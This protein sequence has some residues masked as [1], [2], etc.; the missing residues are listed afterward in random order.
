MASMLAAAA[1]LS[2]LAVASAP[3]DEQ[4]WSFSRESLN[5][6]QFLE[7]GK[8]RPAQFPG[9]PKLLDGGRGVVLDG[10][11]FLTVAPALPSTELPEE[12]LTVEAWVLLDDIGRWGG[13]VSAVE[14]NPGE[15]KGFVLGFRDSRFCFAIATEEHPTLEYVKA[16]GAP[17]LGRWYHVAGTYDGDAAKLYVDGME[18]AR[19]EKPGGR[20]VYADQHQFV[21]GCLKD[22]D[23][24]HPMKGVLLEASL[25]SDSLSS[26]KVSQRFGEGSRDLPQ[27]PAPEDRGVNVATVADIQEKINQAIDKGANWIM[28]RQ[29]RD[30]SWEQAQPGYRNGMTALA[31]YAALKSGVSAEDPGIARALAFLAAE[32]PSK[33]YSAGI[34]MMLIKHLGDRGDRKQAGRI[35]DD[36]LEWERRDFGGGYGYPTGHVDLSCT[37]YGALGL[38]AAHDMGFEAPR[39]VWQRMLE[40]TTT[41][42]MGPVNE[43]RPLV[44]PSGYKGEAA[45]F[46]YR[47][48]STDTGG[49]TTAGLT[50][51]CLAELCAGRKLGSKNLRLVESSK[52]LGAEWL[53]HNWSVSNNPGGG[54][55][56]YYLYGL[57]RVAALL[58]ADVIAGHDW[59]REG[60][61]HLISKQRG[62]G[63]W[64]DGESDTAF[65]LLFLVKA[66]A[67]NTGRSAA[68]ASRAFVR[69]RGPLQFRSTGY[70]RLATWFDRFDEKVL[71]RF[72]PEPGPRVVSMEWLVDGK[73]VTKLPGDPSRPWS[74]ERFAT[75]IELQ[76]PGEAKVRCV[77]TVLSPGE[78]P[79]GKTETL[80]S[81]EL[82]VNAVRDPKEF[83]QAT[84]AFQ[85][86]SLLQEAQYQVLQSSIYAD[87]G[88]YTG[89]M[90]FDNS[91]A[92]R[93]F[94]KVEDK[95][96]WVR[97]ELEKPL[98]AKRIV[99]HPVASSLRME[100]QW[101][102][103]ASATILVN[104]DYEFEV[105]FPAN[106]LMPVRAEIPTKKPI[107]SLE[108]RLGPSQR[109]GRQPGV[110]GLAEITLEK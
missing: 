86:D 30:G 20:I 66:T 4:R 9:T 106:E 74:G 49:M 79:G 38:W 26:R 39:E 6:E 89:A 110:R 53:A 40:V 19:S 32:D 1:L 47:P 101:D 50:V 41:Q 3:Q 103:L 54:H 99:L 109:Q 100:G 52:L 90:A 82:T 57:E 23:A 12:E 44:N 11:Q 35:F 73:Q 76:D 94:A 95:T 108:V 7:A 48:E 10:Q 55:P 93:W 83:L 68:A 15:L 27:P 22:K 75:R 58:E 17:I 80:E 16:P 34:Q 71:E 43:V 25:E 69:D 14:H 36:L 18:V 81:D 24:T 98:R 59:Y 63:S 77:F 72:A 96:P 91:Q 78:E 67:S 13:L 65:A 97:I 51:A 62:N 5:G 85:R 28:S 33:T 31:T 104:G 87:D 60:A 70:M 2:A 56:Y 105:E 21:L 45:G 37:Q 107:R 102:T 8:G 88:R 46:R 61:E 84:A 42:F 64:E 92:T 29:T